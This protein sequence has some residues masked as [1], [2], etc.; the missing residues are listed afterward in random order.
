M[1]SGQQTTFTDGEAYERLMGR[2]SRMVGG[3]FLKWLDVPKGLRWL[4]AGCGNG[5][6]TEEIISHCAPAAVTGIDPSEGQIA[7]ARTRPGTQQADYHIG[8]AQALP[9]GNANFDVAVMAL[10]IAFIP[11]PAK[12]VAEMVRVARPGGLVATYMWDL[13]GGGLPL[14][15]VF[16]ALKSMDLAPPQPPSADVSRREALHQLWVNAKLQAVATEVFRISVT[17]ANFDD[18]WESNALP[19]GPQGKFIQSLAPAAKADLRQ[20]LRDR[21]PTSPDGRIAYESFANAVK[22]RLAT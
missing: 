21:L 10:A 3:P 22:G 12:A 13:P 9:F 17:F 2:W 14:N 19:A 8:D 1:M 20:R 15:P 16:G 7:Y 18:F 11:D 6:F 5:A 4:D